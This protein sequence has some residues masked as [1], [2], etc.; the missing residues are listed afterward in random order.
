MHT[1]LIIHTYSMD[2]T[3]FEL[4]FFYETLHCI[5]HRDAYDKLSSRQK[6][7]GNRNISKMFRAK[8][9]FTATHVQIV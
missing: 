5:H 8:D 3:M 7:S 6:N 4:L 2:Q 9:K 1:A